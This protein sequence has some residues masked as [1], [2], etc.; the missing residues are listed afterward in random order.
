MNF[1]NEIRR[2]SPEGQEDVSY[3]RL[4]PYGL[5]PAICPSCIVLRFHF[6]QKQRRTEN[7]KQKTENRAG[8]GIIV[9]ERPSWLLFRC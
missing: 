5:S 6:R 3:R 1:G 2:I 7:R 9:T 4:D 8:D